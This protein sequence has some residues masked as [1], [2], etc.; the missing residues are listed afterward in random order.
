MALWS[1]DAP[2]GLTR[3][4]FGLIIGGTWGLYATIRGRWV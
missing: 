1:W 2:W 4:N 3:L